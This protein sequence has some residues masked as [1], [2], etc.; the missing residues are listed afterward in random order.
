MKEGISMIKERVN[1]STYR[2]SFTNSP[3]DDGRL[4]NCTI[5]SQNNLVLLSSKTSGCYISNTIDF[6]LF[7]SLVASWKCNT[8]NENSIELLIQVRREDGKWSDLMSYGNWTISEERGSTK[9]SRNN[10]ASINIDTISLNNPSLGNAVR[11]KVNLQR[12]DEYSASPVLSNIFISLNTLECKYKERNIP[13]DKEI[14]IRPRSQRIVEGIGDRICSATSLA[15]VMEYYNRC[16]TTEETANGVYDRFN[17]IYGNWSFNVAFA[18]EQGLT[19]YVSYLKD[20]NLLKEYIADGKPIICSVKTKD[21]NDLKGSPQSY[22]NGHLI[23]VSGFKFENNKE[24][25]VTNDPAWHLERKVRT[26]YPINDFIKAW[27]G[28]AYIIN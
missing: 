26:L 23:V 20:V 21:Q 22:P 8:S 14:A 1:S 25:V 27:S 24:Y 18:N 19:S 17:D 15:M 4:S 10:I 12:D 7:K 9:P 5:D 28:V 13:I 16:L 3:L 6:E 2:F 11:F